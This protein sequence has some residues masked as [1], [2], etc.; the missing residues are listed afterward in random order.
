MKYSW[1]ILTSAILCSTA[2]QPVWAQDVQPEPLPELPFEADMPLGEPDVAAER[3]GNPDP[4][5][6]AL[7]SA[8]KLNPRI[9]A[10]QRLVEQQDERV[11]QSLANFRPNLSANY[12]RGRQRT[13]FEG[14]D[15]NYGDTEAQ[16]LSLEQ[17]LFQGGGN[18]YR[19]YSAK[20]N[21]LSARADFL[22]AQQQVLLE[23]ITAYMDVVQNYSLL[24]LS[25]NN[26]DVLG[27][28]L[29]ASNER[30]EVGDV[31]RTDVAQ[32]EARLSG[33]RAETIQARA[34]LESS[35]A[36]FE[37]LVG[38]KPTLPLPA[39]D[40]F[41]PLPETKE[42]AIEQALAKNPSIDSFEHLKQAA[43]EDIGVSVSSLLPKVSLVGTMTRQDGAGVNGTSQFD[44]DSVQLSV[45]VPL[46]QRGAEYSRVRESKI[47]AK[48]RE[49]LLLDTEQ[50]VRESV[51][52][53]WENWQAA[54]STITAQEEAIRA[55]EVALD[56]VR[57]EQQYGSRTILD[58][59][60]AE[61]ELFIAR[62]N[63]TRAQRNRIVAIY[64]LH[65]T[66][67]DLLPGNLN[68]AVEQ[69]DPTKHYDDVKW[70]LIG[71]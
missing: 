44:T 47:L 22:S 70:R 40:Q 38:Y 41:P 46:Y 62:V 17:P 2:L 16:Q 67:G 1:L 71:F 18:F 21:M 51:I 54:V 65:L 63:L 10:S 60:D 68:L 12:D 35:I 9:Q 42:A 31:T 58:V 69:Y 8:Y 64:N 53:A 49:H 37:R 3:A 50:F 43:E 28:Q 32:S 26:A 6:Q 34:N 57:Q 4:F 66:L 7:E 36:S 13:R 56:G 59:L 29:T 27:R 52:R 23:S 20:E 33:A 48:R 55:A 25:Q 5:A 39:P 24:E 45:S 11:S 61:Q 14:S 30:F 19:F 15:W